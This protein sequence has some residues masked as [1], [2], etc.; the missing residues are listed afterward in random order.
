MLTLT[1]IIVLAVLLFVTQWLPLEVTSLLILPALFFTGLL[2]AEQVFSGFSNGAT[3]TIGAMFV[4]SAGL[5]RTGALDP[6]MA[7]FRRYAHGNPFRVLVMLAL[8]LPLISAFMN[9]TPVV[10]MMVPVLLS[11]SREMGIKPSKLMI[12]LSYFTILGG[13]LTL[14]GTSTNIIVNELYRNAGGP[15]FR[16]FEFTPMG[17]VYCAGGIAFILFVGRRLLPDRAPLSAMVPRERTAEFVTEIVVEDG[18]PLIGRRAGEIFQRGSNVQLLQLV[19]GEEIVPPGEGKEMQL[20]G[21]DALIVEGTSKRIAELI[22]RWGASLAKVVEDDRYVPMR[23]TQL[24]LGEAVVLPDSPFVGRKVG[25]LALNRSYGARVLAVQR[26]GRHHRRVRE[27][28]LRPGDVL[29]LQ[30]EARSFARLR[31]SEAVLLVEGLEQEVAHK[32][33]RKLAIPI[34]L[35]VIAL[36]SLTSLPISMVAVSG[37]LLMVLTRCLRV[38]EAIR[39]IDLSVLFLLIGTIPLGL[40]MQRT[41]LAHEIVDATLAITGESSPAL[42]VSAFYVLTVVMTALLSNSATAVLLTPIALGLASS[43][44][45]DAKPFL[46][47]VAF[48]AS[49]DFSTPIGYQTNTIVFGPGGYRFSD[50]LKIGL[51]LEFLMWALASV[52]IPIFWPFRPG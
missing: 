6:L 23:T 10:V 20:A 50:Y 16:L 18:S 29:L 43:L 5:S 37:A 48:G 35:G 27:M 46:I 30:G 22:T 8:T 49:A 4:L 28:E 2:P 44:G 11:L 32:R 36:A 40:A 51:P 12:P 42:L 31:E 41:G 9:N 13:T 38:D 14:I 3:I 17:L 15:G 39:A 52:L 1:I 47:A 26:S 24:M 25:E 45:V 34:M 7:L 19:R 21:G 33:G